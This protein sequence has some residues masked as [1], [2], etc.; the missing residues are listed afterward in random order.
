MRSHNHKDTEPDPLFAGKCKT[1]TGPTFDVVNQNTFPI[2]RLE[3]AAAVVTAAA[4][5]G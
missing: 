1:R 5:A 4:N 2:I 3:E